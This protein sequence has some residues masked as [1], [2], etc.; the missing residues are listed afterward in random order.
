MPAQSQLSYEQFL[1]R[2]HDRLT[3]AER[4]ALVG[5]YY[6]REMY[7]TERLPLQRIEALGDSVQECVATLRRRGL[8]PLNYEFTRF[9]P[10]Y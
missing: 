1:G 8:D 5:K 10:S 6:A 9:N 3:L 2:A 7:T 4:E